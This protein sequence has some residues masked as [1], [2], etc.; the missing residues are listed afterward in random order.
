[1]RHP[2]PIP[3]DRPPHK[4]RNTETPSQQRSSLNGLDQLLKSS[5]STHLKLTSNDGKS[6]IVSMEV[7]GVMYQGMLFAV[8]TATNDLL[9][10]GDGLSELFGNEA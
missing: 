6:M 4:Q 9:M 7:N 5:A 10:N 1:M 8:N 3:T 2:S